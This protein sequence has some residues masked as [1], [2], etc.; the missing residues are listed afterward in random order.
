M[1]C[2]FTLHTIFRT[3][4]SAPADIKYQLN[5]VTS[6]VVLR[7]SLSQPFYRNTGGTLEAAS[8]PDSIRTETLL[9]TTHDMQEALLKVHNLIFTSDQ[10]TSH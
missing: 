6:D 8:G 10:A 9:T 5:N 3:S 7:K 1:E 2:S 4:W